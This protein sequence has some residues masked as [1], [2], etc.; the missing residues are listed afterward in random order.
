MKTIGFPYVV[1]SEVPLFKDWESEDRMIGT[2]KLVK[3][4]RQGRSF[5][6]EDTYPETSQVVYNYQEWLV[7]TPSP[8]N[9]S[10]IVPLIIKIR[11]IDS[12]G[13]ANS[14]DDITS[15]YE[16][17][18]LPINFISIHGIEVF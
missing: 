7:H 5:I 12:I 15:N 9:S 4:L 10:Q 17:N 1:G 14:R 8:L 18:L 16:D 3:F 6:L 11:Y 13:V 2:A